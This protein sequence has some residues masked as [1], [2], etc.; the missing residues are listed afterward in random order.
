M[1]KGLIKGLMIIGAIIMLYSFLGFFGIFK[2]YSN[3]T[4]ANEPNLEF[5][6]RMIVSNLADLEKG[7]FICYDY[8]SEYF[9]LATRVHRLIAKEG[10]VIEIK[11][12]DVYVNNI[13][14]DKNNNLMHYYK[15]NIEEFKKLRD[16]GIIN[17]NSFASSLDKNTVKVLFDD[18]FA[19]QNGYNDRVIDSVGYFEEKISAYYDENWNKDNFGPLVIP[20]DKY[21]VLGDNRDFSEDSRVIGFIDKSDIVG[22]V[23]KY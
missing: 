18:S 19:K 9:G 16:S 12:G 7:K 1:K 20:K 17:E 2:I 5:N 3:P 6:S 14:F 10:D 22:V 15:L 11:N 21:F 23:I 4:V 8:D 13:L